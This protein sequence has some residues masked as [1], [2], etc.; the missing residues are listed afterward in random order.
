MFKNKNRPGIRK[1]NGL[2]EGMGP[3]F[4]FFVFLQHGIV[5][6]VYPELKSRESPILSCSV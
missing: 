5:V 3:S 4:N 6:R 1:M 2:R